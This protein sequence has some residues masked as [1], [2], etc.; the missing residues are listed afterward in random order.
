MY[1]WLVGGFCATSG[2][3]ITFALIRAKRYMNSDTDAMSRE[4]FSPVHYEPMKRLLS[5]EDFNFLKSRPGVGPALVRRLR[6]QRRKVFRT[7]LRELASD[8]HRLHDE[9]R[10]ML[11]VAPEEYSDLVPTLMRAQMRFWTALAGVEMRLALHTFGIC[12]VDV[13]G[14]LAPLEALHSAIHRT[15]AGL[16]PI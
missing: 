10:V 11:T 8:F 15:T 12:Q 1:Q 9:A 16:E 6:V 13:R 7:Y 5:E 14:L 2:S 4:S 3:A